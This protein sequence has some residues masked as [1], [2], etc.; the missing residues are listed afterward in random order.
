MAKDPRIRSPRVHVTA[1]NDMQIL[2]WAS[3]EQREAF[4]YGPF[5]ICASGGFGAAKTYALCL[6]ALWL[7]DTYPKN[8]GI[9]ARRVRDDLLRTTMTTFFKLCS[10]KA[11]EHGKRSDSE[12]Y[13][14]LNN[15]S[16]ILWCYFDKQSD[17]EIQG[18]VRGVEINWFLLDQAEEMSEEIFSTL[19]TRLSRWDMAEV[20]ELMLARYGGLEK[21]PFR[22][23]VTGKAVPPPYP[24]VACNP[25]L[26]SHWIYRRFHPD[27]PDHILRNIPVIDPISGQ[28]TGK[29]TSYQELGYRMVTMDSLKNK[30]LP[31]STRQELMAMDENWRKR[32]VHGQW[33]N[34]EG[35]IHA[36]SKESEIQG[37]PELAEYLLRNCRLQMVLDHGDSAPTCVGFFAV[38]REGNCIVLGEYYQPGKL[39]SY[40]R[41]EIAR[42]RKEIFPGDYAMP[43]A[44][45]S[46]FHKQ[47]QKN[48]GL[49]ATADEYLDT[50]IA[51]RETI[52]CWQPADNN[53]LGT[54]NR[55]NEY[56]KVD[57]NHINPFTKERGS[58]RLFFLKA[59]NEYPFG[60][61]NI[62]RELKAQRRKKIGTDRG[63]AIFSDIREEQVADHGYDVVRYFIAGRPS[64]A[65][66]SVKPRSR[67]TWKA[68]RD[69]AIR[70]KQG[71]EPNRPP[72][73][74]SVE[75]VN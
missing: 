26:E 28:E 12:W 14:R 20:P 9:I 59:N 58:P 55:V 49:W 34:P 65:P 45:P 60:V 53:E 2:D 17:E 63:R 22:N 7:S 75:L 40:H 71:G 31:M 43:L 51:P 44:D 48:G 24:M 29:F 21:W 74:A 46:I 18:L 32:F 15:G 1:Q 33:G 68:C 66:A 16:E 56:L 70:Y 37:S 41:V 72:R 23:P 10:A 67:R 35:Q 73:P 57:P 47:A 50:K 25:D 13:L 61:N 4:E 52:I 30:Y 27:S 42:I 6:K 5:P 54:R 11:Y 64:L 19:V 69:D 3:D 8:R 38:D 39:I 36:V 62:L